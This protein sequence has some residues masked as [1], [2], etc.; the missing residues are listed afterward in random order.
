M[1]EIAGGN[2]T[3]LPPLPAQICGFIIDHSNFVDLG[4]RVSQSDR[5]EGEDDRAGKWLRVA[6]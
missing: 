2:P 1:R 3:S 4:K 6:R 5:R